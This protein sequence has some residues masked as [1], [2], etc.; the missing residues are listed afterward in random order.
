MIPRAPWLEFA[1]ALA[2]GI[3]LAILF[4]ALFQALTGGPL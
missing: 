3:A 1:F 2:G 4:W